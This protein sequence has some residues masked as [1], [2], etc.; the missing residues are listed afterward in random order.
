MTDQ[1]SGHNN[2]SDD[3]FLDEVKQAALTD[4]NGLPASPVTETVEE[5]G[6]HHRG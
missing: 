1:T 6:T 5:W 4:S 2:E 3:R